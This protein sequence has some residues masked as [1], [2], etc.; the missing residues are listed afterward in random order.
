MGGHDGCYLIVKVNDTKYYRFVKKYSD[1]Q[2]KS[3]IAD[4]KRHAAGGDESLIP[5]LT[6]EGFTR[7]QKAPVGD[8]EEI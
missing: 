3:F 4:A 8:A 7:S 1:A 5:G 2:E 6:Q